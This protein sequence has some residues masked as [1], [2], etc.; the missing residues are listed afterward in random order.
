MQQE[1]GR[2]GGEGAGNNVY[3]SNYI[4]ITSACS[5]IFCDNYFRINRLVVKKKVVG[6]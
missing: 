3:D 4:V 2:Q 5:K 6:Q 1:C